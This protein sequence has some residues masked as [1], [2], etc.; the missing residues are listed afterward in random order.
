MSLQSRM[1]AR[2]I[3]IASANGS[4]GWVSRCVRDARLAEDGS[5]HAGGG[6]L[7]RAP[8]RSITG[9]KSLAEIERY[10]KAADQKRMATAAIHRLERNRNRT[11]SGKRPRLEVANEWLDD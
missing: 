3:A 4:S 5:A 1:E 2:S 6:W 9:H 11:A 8:D 10:T 7:Q